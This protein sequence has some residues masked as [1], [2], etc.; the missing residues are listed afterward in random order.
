MV[1]AGVERCR[2]RGNVGWVSSMLRDVH[3]VNVGAL[4]R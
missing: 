1:L 2:F 3:E 4:R